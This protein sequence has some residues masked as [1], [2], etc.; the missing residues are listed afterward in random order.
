ML[1]NKF[2]SPETTFDDAAVALAVDDVILLNPVT[3]S[4]LLITLDEFLLV[5][6]PLEP[7]TKPDVNFF[8]KV[9]L[10]WLSF[11]LL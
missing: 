4:K 7:E 3:D 1:L 2:V 5:T 6:K 8:M 10:V 9:R 11:K